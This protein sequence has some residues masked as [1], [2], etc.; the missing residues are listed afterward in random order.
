MA[1]ALGVSAGF[2]SSTPAADPTGNSSANFDG[3]ADA[4]KD[5]S[6]V[7]AGKITEVGFYINSLPAA[8]DFEIGLY[9]HNSGSDVPDSLLY[10]E[11][12]TSAEI[13]LGWNSF[14]GLDWT[15]SPSTVYW[16]AAQGDAVAGTPYIDLTTG[17]ERFSYQASLGSL[18][19][20]WSATATSANLPAI[21][22]LWDTG[23]TYVELSGTIAA[24]SVVTNADLGILTYIS[25]SGTI[26]AQ[27]TVAN[28][29]LGFTAV[30][31]GE[32]VAT[33]R[34]VAVGN[35]QLWYEA[36]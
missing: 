23:V 33:K 32:S 30:T 8:G 35:N 36:I 13:S 6:P 22:A 17:I 15:I 11:A 24:Q 9:S 10:S 1:V 19:A 28:A 31:L 4:V 5:T 3:A 16:I 29:S 2:C 14:S 34:L 7:G 25:L 26:A 20:T 18:P 12:H 27:S 21:Y